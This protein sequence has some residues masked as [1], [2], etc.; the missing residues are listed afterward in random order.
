[1]VRGDKVFQIM[2]KFYLKKIEVLVIIQSILIIQHIFPGKVNTKE[3]KNMRNEKTAGITLT[4][5]YD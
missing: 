2:G 1:M 3:V 4:V 5:I